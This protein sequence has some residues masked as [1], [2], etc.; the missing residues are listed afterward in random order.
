MKGDEEVKVSMNGNL[1]CFISANHPTTSSLRTQMISAEAPIL[2][3]KVAEAFI[4]EV[5]LRAWE[6]TEENKRRTL[7]VG[8]YDLSNFPSALPQHL[9]THQREHLPFPRKRTDVTRAIGKSDL[10][11]FLIDLIPREDSKPAKVSF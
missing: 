1:A 6:H 11:D 5:T 4:Y 7:Q 8:T 3:A 2:F 10:F 9:P